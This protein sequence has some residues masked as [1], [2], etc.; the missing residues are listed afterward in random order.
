MKEDPEGILKAVFD[1]VN[2]EDTFARLIGMKLIELQP[3]FARA[4]L[5]VT[6]ATINIYQ[7][8]HGK[9]GKCWQIWRP[10]SGQSKADQ[11]IQPHR[12][13]RIRSQESRRASYRNRPATYLL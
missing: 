12:F 2:S 11:P 10:P 8:A 4:T 3:G 5:P 6:H 13:N 1:K 9:R 7:M